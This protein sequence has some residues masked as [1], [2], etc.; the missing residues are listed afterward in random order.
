MLERNPPFRQP[1]PKD[2]VLQTFLSRKT[3]DKDINLWSS[4]DEESRT[5]PLTSYSLC[6]LL[7]SISEAEDRDVHVADLSSDAC[8]YLL[9]FLFI[10]IGVYKYSQPHKFVHVSKHR[11]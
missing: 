9:L 1:F 11:P 2:C 10:G 8:H 6:S 3:P 7:N 4:K 5:K